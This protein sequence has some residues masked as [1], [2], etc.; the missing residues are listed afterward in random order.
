MSAFSILLL[1]LISVPLL[2]I[3]IL[4]SVGQVIGAGTTI[5]VVI[6]TAVLGAWLLRLQGLA[7][8]KRVQEATA[9]GEL[10]AGELIEGA[11]LLV[12]GALL[13]TPGFVTDAIGFACLVPA[14]R[15]ALARRLIAQIATRATVVMRS[16]NGRIIEG[17]F[18]RDDP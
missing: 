4:I 6:A 15:Q 9:R 2:E 14:V 16:A 5:L 13:L 18:H 11:I 7:T 1:L 8:I 17:D 10:P 3:Y 12:T